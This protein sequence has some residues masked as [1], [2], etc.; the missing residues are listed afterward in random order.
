M[1]TSVFFKAIGKS[2]CLKIIQ[3]IGGHRHI[4]PVVFILTMEALSLA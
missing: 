3:L 4:V 2:F 1:D